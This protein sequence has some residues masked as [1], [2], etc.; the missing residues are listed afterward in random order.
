MR[1]LIFSAAFAL[2]RPRE[3]DNNSNE[4]Q[5]VVTTPQVQIGGSIN[6]N[7]KNALGKDFV[8]EILDKDGVTVP[9]TVETIKNQP[10]TRGFQWKI[11][12]ECKDCMLMVR[13]GKVPPSP[14]DSIVGAFSNR[15]SVIPKDE[16]V[17]LTVAFDK[18]GTTYEPTK[19]V[20]VTVKVTNVP[21]DKE[22]L[23]A[24]I[25]LFADEKPIKNS[26]VVQTLKALKAD[27][28]VK[29]PGPKTSMNDQKLHVK[30]TVE[31]DGNKFTWNSEKT[32]NVS[33]AAIVGSSAALLITTFG[34]LFM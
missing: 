21:H 27:G 19:E 34:M 33:G 31:D 1:T 8:C 3:A 16:L 32:V 9:K 17:K 10:D 20:P 22:T 11:K 29:I 18:P 23:N 4:F 7:L 26:K 15:F 13:T 30:V 5:V 24:S 14:G 6:F 25:S 28:R 2:A 12:T